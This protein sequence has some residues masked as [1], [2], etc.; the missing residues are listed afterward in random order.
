M[1]IQKRS[2]LKAKFKNGNIPFEEDFWDLIDTLISQN[3]D[4]IAIIKNSDGSYSLG[5]GVQKTG[6]APLSIAYQGEKQALISFN[7]PKTETPLWGFALLNTKSAPGFSI[8]QVLAE[9]KIAM[10]RLFIDSK[11]GNASFGSELPG[12]MLH[13]EKSMPAGGAGVQ[14]VNTA[15]TAVQTGWRL[16]HL[17]DNSITTRNGAFVIT[18]A[19]DAKTTPIEYLILTRDGKLGLREKTPDSALH[20]SLPAAD[21]ASYIALTKN[22]GIAQFGEA[23][24][25]V[26][27]DNRG[28]QAR[29]GTVV[30]GEMQFSVTTLNLQRLGGDLVLH[31][32]DKIDESEKFIVKADGKVGMGV[33]IPKSR[34]HLDGRIIVGDGA[35]DPETGAIRWSGTDFE[36]FDGTNWVSMT[37]GAASLWSIAGTNKI[38]YNQDNGMVGIG[39]DVPQNP[40][41]IVDDS[42]GQGNMRSVFIQNNSTSSSS[43]LADK[44]VGLHVVNSGAWNDQPTAINVGIYSKATGSG[45]V[46]ANLAAVLN[47]NVSIGALSSSEEMVGMEGNNVL[48]I[49]PGTSPLSQVGGVAA[50]GNGIQIYSENN[51]IG[52]SVFTLMNGNGDKITLAKGAALTAAKTNTVDETYGTEEAEVINNLRTRVNE[53]ETRLKALGLL[54]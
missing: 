40:L 35:E 21:A 36:G 29:K 53:L 44:R 19:G 8:V 23:S 48:V 20:V 37:G 33:L 42:A 4:G 11:T 27:L 43:Q 10:T 26:L 34:L 15:A 13:V 50:T 14:I 12:D 18:T 7:E 45:N 25:S 47:G 41:H 38:T 6:L 32:D 54:A 24:G 28:V 1:S 5:I 30:G 17:N 51:A 39:V 46:N 49:Q 3:E 31:G 52:V 22:T 9:K 2:Y 16:Q